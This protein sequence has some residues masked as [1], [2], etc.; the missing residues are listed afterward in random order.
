MVVVEAAAAGLV[1][2][3]AMGQNLSRAEIAAARGLRA[4]FGGAGNHRLLGEATWGN[5]AV[6]GSCEWDGEPG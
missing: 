3:S 1:T 6:S 4:N 2:M 5:L